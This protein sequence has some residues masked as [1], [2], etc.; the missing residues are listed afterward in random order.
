MKR[1]PLLPIPKTA[2][3]LRDA[4][5]DEI[6]RMRQGAGSPQEARAL[7]SL[8]AQIIDSLRVQIQNNRLIDET[9]KRGRILLGSEN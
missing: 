1:E 8:A 3:G 6:N 9:R 5:F 7:C 4:L 2:E